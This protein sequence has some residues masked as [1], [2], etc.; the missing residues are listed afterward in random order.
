MTAPL[1][2]GLNRLN[3]PVLL[4][5]AIH[6]T[7]SFIHVITYTMALSHVACLA[8]YYSYNKDGKIGIC[9]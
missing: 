4:N 3:Y 2:I 9:T 7:I 5:F 8:L 6:L 1:C